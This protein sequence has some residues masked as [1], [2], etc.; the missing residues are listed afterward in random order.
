MRS[1]EDQDFAS[2]TLRR[3][4]C[5]LALVPAYQT[6]LIRRL[7]PEAKGS[8]DGCEPEGAIRVLAMSLEFRWVSGRAP[9][10]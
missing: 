4:F 5:D 7:F 9:A 8:P 1:D 6:A 3:R 10:A 2:R